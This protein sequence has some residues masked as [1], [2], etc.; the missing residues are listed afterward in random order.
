VRPNASRQSKGLISTTSS[1]FGITVLLIVS[2][3][4]NLELNCFSIINIYRISFL[5]W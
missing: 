4:K 2:G 1:N 3:L 5:K